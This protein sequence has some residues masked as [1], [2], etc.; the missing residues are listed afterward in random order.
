MGDA[1]QAGAQ[2]LITEEAGGLAQLRRNVGRFGL[3]VE[4]LY[5]LLANHLLLESP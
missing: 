1:R 2:L 4:S 3:Q 5:P